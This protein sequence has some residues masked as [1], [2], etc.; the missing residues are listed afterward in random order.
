MCT[1]ILHIYSKTIVTGGKNMQVI[2]VVDNA[3]NEKE[4]RIFI[5]F[6]GAIF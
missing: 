2:V 3:E 5:N 4:R 1:V 6:C